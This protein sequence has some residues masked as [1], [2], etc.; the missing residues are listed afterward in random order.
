MEVAR[1]EKWMRRDEVA[2]MLGVGKQTVSRWKIPCVKCGCL[3]LYD[4]VVVRDFM[5]QKGGREA[6]SPEPSGV[7]PRKEMP[8]EADSLYG[9]SV[10]LA[11]GLYFGSVVTEV[12]Y[13]NGKVTKV[14]RQR[15]ENYLEKGDV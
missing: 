1:G 14:T 3:T 6:V 5:R 2:A 10:R 11:D 4:P 9:Q 12:F 15:R 13:H 8:S 7:E